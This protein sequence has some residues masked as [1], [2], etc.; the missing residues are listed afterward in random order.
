MKAL[1]E[2]F[3]FEQLP[4]NTRAEVLE[5]F[6]TSPT[7]V[8]YSPGQVFYR[9][10]T[11]RKGVEAELSGNGIL[12]GYWW[13]DEQTRAHLSVLAWR[14]KIAFAKAARSRL[15]VTADFNREMEYFCS[16]YLTAEVYGW[17]GRA[18][19]QDDK[20][21]RITYPGGSNQI[22]FP[23]LAANKDKTSSFVARIKMWAYLD[24]IC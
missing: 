8:C 21:L 14:Q 5:A 17:A 24:E 11:P 22:Y 7:K 12:D 16:I 4:S 3:T 6:T 13:F 19:W 18:R 1:N 15:G 10:V 9:F 2:D 20:Q 23:S